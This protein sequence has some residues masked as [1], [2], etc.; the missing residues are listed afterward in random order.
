MPLYEGFAL[1]SDKHS[2]LFEFGTAYTK[3]GFVNDYSPRAI[4]RSELFYEPFKKVVRLSS[5]KNEEH[6]NAALRQFIEMLY[7][8]F[9]AVNP[10]DRRVIV[11]ENLFCESTFRKVLT[12]VLFNYFDVP[13]VLYLPQHLMALMTLLIPSGLV[14]DV[15][16]NECTVIP[17]IEGV[18]CLDS[19][20][21]AP[22]GSKAIHERI[23]Q[24]LKSTESKVI[25]NTETKTICDEDIFDDSLLENIKVRL[26]FV[27]PFERGQRL[28]QSDTN[29]DS[30]PEDVKYPADGTKIIDIRGIVRERTAEVLFEDFEN[31]QSIATLILD[32]ILKCPLDT[33][34]LLA[35]NIVLVGGTCILPGFK[36]R[37]LSELKSLADSSR[38]KDRI[39]FKDFLFHSPPSKENY[40]CWLGASIFGATDAVNTR[41][42]TRDQYLKSNGKVIGDWCTWYPSKNAIID[43]FYSLNE[44]LTASS[45]HNSRT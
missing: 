17:I 28:Q 29:L 33:R 32:S 26:C 13:S 20:H 6:L 24:E 25:T 16:Y 19:V 43:I 27:A 30:T 22:L 38:Y 21:F 18:T 40:T 31:E 4:I 8:R 23:Y 45:K 44:K 3:C 10:K 36:H 11:V 39:Y 15:G 34:K 12:N 2:I 1:G 7:F 42:V 14:V 9:L 5:I 35:T 37:L 41:S